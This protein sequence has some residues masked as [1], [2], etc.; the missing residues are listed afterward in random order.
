[1]GFGIG[2]WALLLPALVNAD[3]KAAR[4]YVTLAEGLKCAFKELDLV[5]L[6]GSLSTL[7]IL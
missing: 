7:Y 1:M 3:P 6:D 5:I 2:F 4:S